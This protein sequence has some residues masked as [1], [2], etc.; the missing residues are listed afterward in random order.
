MIAEASE[1]ETFQASTEKT[2]FRV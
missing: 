2:H 1:L